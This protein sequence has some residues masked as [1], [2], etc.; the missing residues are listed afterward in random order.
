MRSRMCSGYVIIRFKI[1]VSLKVHI[2]ILDMI[3][4]SLVFEY[5]ILGAKCCLYLLSWRTED[6]SS[7]FLRSVNIN[8]RL[9]Y[10]SVN[11]YYYYWCS[12][13]F[14]WHNSGI[15][16]PCICV[17]CMFRPIV[18]IIRY[19]KFSSHLSFYLLYS[20]AL[21]SV[22]TLGVRCTGIIIIIYLNGKWVSTRWQ[23]YYNRTTHK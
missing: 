2:V 21:A 11:L 18:A 23:W 14:S 17:Y 16:T 9:Q 3:P 10:E 19:I 8:K 22:Y 13:L 12:L 1:F 7:L 20:P 5:K 6:V 15:N 4:C